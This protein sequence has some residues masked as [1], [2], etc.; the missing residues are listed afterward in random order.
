MK[1]LVIGTVIVATATAQ[2]FTPVKPVSAPTAASLQI[3]NGR[4]FSYALPPGWR[5]GEDGQFALTLVSA[6]TRAL[7][8]MVGNAGLPPNYPPARFV[9]EKL[10]AMQ[11]QNLQIGPPRQAKPVAGF[12]QAI[13]F[14]VSFTA[15]GF[16]QRGVAKCNINTAYDTAVMAM[17]AAVSEASQWA[18]YATWLPQV[19]DQ[20]SATNGAAF[21][22]RGI[23]QQ[24]LRNSM[25]Y[26]EAARNYREWSQRNWQAVTDQRNASED[27]RNEARRDNLGGVQPYMNPY[28]D[29]RKVELPVT[30]RHYWMDHD[31]NI[32]G[33]DD[34]NADPNVGSKSEWRRMKPSR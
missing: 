7:T 25:A 11:P 8:I 12:R 6:D 18:G 13:E 14:D 20:I 1:F 16:R 10:M 21:G 22:V 31:G 9:T 32:V 15:R 24:N 26:A 28:G 33:T 23:M 2:K 5:V 17:T 3:G 29:N 19:A 27:R 4:F 30:Y 34:P